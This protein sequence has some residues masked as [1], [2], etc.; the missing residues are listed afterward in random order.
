MVWVRLILNIVYDCLYAGLLP[1]EAQNLQSAD[2]LLGLTPT[3]LSTL[4]PSIGEISLLSTRRRFLALLLAVANPSIYVSRL[5]SFN[6]PMEYLNPVETA[7]PDGFL[8]LQGRSATVLA[9]LQYILAAGAI[10][11]VVHLSWE[12]GY[13]TVIAWKCN[14]S[15]IPFLWTIIPLF[16]HIIAAVGWHISNS[17]R[18]ANRLEQGVASRSKVQQMAMQEGKLPSQDPKLDFKTPWR[19]FQQQPPSHKREKLAIFLNELAG[20]GAFLHLLFGTTVFSSLMFIGVLDALQVIARY[21]ASG[22]I[23]RLIVSWELAAMRAARKKLED[24]AGES[25]AQDSSKLDLPE[26]QTF[27]MLTT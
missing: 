5:L 2:V 19:D 23:C 10:V 13:R 22:L 4:A 15:Y 11:N 16:V 20:F 9:S 18:Q 25:R 24:P 27:P 6:D 3:L 14:A 8:S 7:F 21:I 1:N 26:R 12:L 17:V